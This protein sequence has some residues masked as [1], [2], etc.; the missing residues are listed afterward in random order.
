M[1]L[2]K[3]WALPVDVCHGKQQQ[4]SF[5]TCLACEQMTKKGTPHL[6]RWI[7]F[8]LIYENVV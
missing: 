5:N 1:V 2:Q 7:S 4:I 8:V 3:E 6:T